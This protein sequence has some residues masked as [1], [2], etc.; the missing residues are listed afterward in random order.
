MKAL[1][2]PG[3]ELIN[4]CIYV[5]KCSLASLC[6]R[7]EAYVNSGWWRAYFFRSG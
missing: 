2:S 1:Y 7:L 4:A 6:S 5:L 3:V